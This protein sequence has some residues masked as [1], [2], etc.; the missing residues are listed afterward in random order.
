MKYK[1]ILVNDENEV[2]NKP[3]V[4][5]VIRVIKGKP[6]FLNEHLIR[7]KN[8]IKHFS[9]TDFDV[10]LCKT[11]I[12]KLIENEKIVNQNIRM[13]TG[14]F[15]DENLSYKIFSI[16]S[17]YPSN[18]IYL[19]CVD[20]I[21]VYKNRDNPKIKIRNDEFKLYIKNKLKDNNMYEAILIDENENILEGSRSNL[22]F[23][24]GNKII[25]S[26]L[27][28]VLEGITLS[29]VVKVINQTK[30]EI[31]RENINKKDLELF[32]GAFLTGTSIDILPINKIDDLKFNTAVNPII[33][34]LMN[35]FNEFKL[36]DMR[37]L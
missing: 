37:G 3:I 17:N 29:N 2:L 34:D 31:V 23:I 32:D 24:K 12:F 7:M 20:V 30:L 21:T 15:T 28:G 13:E 22:F 36:Q 4:Y 8:S 1:N 9:K 26:K 18:K 6:L 25:T 14:N 35:K 5:E 11:R 33:L 10:N 19:E 27:G 16:V